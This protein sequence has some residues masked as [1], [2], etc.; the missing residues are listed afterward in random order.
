MRVSLPPACTC[1]SWFTKPVKV[2]TS[3]PVVCHASPASLL[4][5]HAH[6]VCLV[7]RQVLEGHGWRSIAGPWSLCGSAGVWLWAHR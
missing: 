4:F 6:T 2:C 1:L 5:P 3:K 7:W